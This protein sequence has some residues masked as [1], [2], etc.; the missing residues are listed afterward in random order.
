[1]IA[2]GMTPEN[3]KNAQDN[4]DAQFRRMFRAMGYTRIG[5]RFEK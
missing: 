2:H 1:M 3:I 4:A 5:I